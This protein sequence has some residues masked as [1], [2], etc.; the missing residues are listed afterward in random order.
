MKIMK[1]D[2]CFY[3]SIKGINFLGGNWDV[4]VKKRGRVV[5]NFLDNDERQR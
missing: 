5:L 3:K 1:I 4:G 2:I